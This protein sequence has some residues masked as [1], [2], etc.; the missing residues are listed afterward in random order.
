VDWGLFIKFAAECVTKNG[1]VMRRVLFLVAIV[2][3]V[4]CNN[5][6]QTSSDV[7]DYDSIE[8]VTDVVDSIII[9]TQITTPTNS[10]ISLDFSSYHL[11]SSEEDKYDADGFQPV[12]ANVTINEETNTASLKL[13][14]S[15]TKQWYTFPF[16]IEERINMQE[17][18]VVYKVINN[19]N[20]VSYIYVSTNRPNGLFIDINHFSFDGPRI[21]CWMQEG[22]SSGAEYRNNAVRITPEEIESIV[23]DNSSAPTYNPN[24]N[25]GNIQ[26][27]GRVYGNFSNYEETNDC[28]EGV[29]VYEGDDDYYIVETRKGYTILERYSGR[30]DEGDKVRGELNR[31]NFKYLIN[32]N[33]D[34]EV[35]VYIEDYMLSKD[36]ALEWM[37]EKDHLKSR[38]QEVYDYNKDN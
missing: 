26:S 14:D 37:G 1:R 33:K 8:A 22:G 16:R 32:R 18:V 28:V 12:S 35:R 25:S 10:G 38:D 13:Y 6:K 15:G 29:V 24:L 7:Y 21:C 30:L 3:M 17:G 36:R 5:G 9:P 19:V 34:S 2:C 20:Q 31:Y 23:N 4:A 11:Y 27:D